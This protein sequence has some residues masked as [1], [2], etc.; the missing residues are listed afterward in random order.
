MAPAQRRDARI[1]DL[2]SDDAGRGEKRAQ[3]CPVF[4]P[5]GKENHGRRIEPDVHLLEG[6]VEWCRRVEEPRTSHDADELVHAWPG[7]RPCRSALCERRHASPGG[8]VEE[9]VRTV[10]VDED[11]RVDGDHPPRPSS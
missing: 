8:A 3:L 7:N 9:C 5:F 10:C 11:V 2:W 6:G 1:V 4:R